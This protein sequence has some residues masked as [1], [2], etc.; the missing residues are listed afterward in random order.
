[1][2]TLGSTSFLV[3][4]L[5]KNIDVKGIIGLSH[6]YNDDRV[7]GYMNYRDVA[8]ENALEYIEV[9][10]YKLSTSDFNVLSNLEIDVL[11]VLG[12]Q[13][14]IPFWLI[15]N[16]NVGAIGIHGSAYGI[17]RGRG[18]SPQNWA[19]ILGESSFSISIFWIEKGIDSG[20]VIDTEEFLIDKMHDDIKSMYL[21]VSAS[22]YKMIQENLRNGNI[23][24][25]F[26]DVQIEAES[27]YLPQRIP[28]DGQIDWS[29]DNDE[30]MRFIRA[31]TKP[32]P[33]AFSYIEGNLIKIWR[34]RPLEIE[35]CDCETGKIVFVNM[36]NSFIVK[37]D[38]SF[39]L[40]EEHESVIKVEKD[41]MFTSFDKTTQMKEII[42]RHRRKHPRLKLNSTIMKQLSN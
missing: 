5:I 28:E 40:I 35:L 34:A 16:C 42:E 1:M 31:L 26:G 10:E 9:E 22:V 38:E 3:D 30:I 24:G 17:Q 27:E 12:W 6:L 33:G 7:S 39:L 2:S 20:R 23:S 8:N 41:M 32:Y 4:L 11:L 37:T 15:D 29:C 36:D 21:K 14:L 25:R 13:R 19:L 18:R